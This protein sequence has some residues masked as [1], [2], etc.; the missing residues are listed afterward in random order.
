MIDKGRFAIGALGRYSMSRFG[1]TVG[2]RVKIAS[3]LIGGRW[4]WEA[5]VS[6]RFLVWVFITLECG[7]H[8][9]DRRYKVGWMEEVWVRACVH[10][11][12]G[13][14]RIIPSRC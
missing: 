1:N 10:V 13:W 8:H 6:H 4:E 11:C 9:C 2:R 7:T 14:R 5:M 3:C 12:V